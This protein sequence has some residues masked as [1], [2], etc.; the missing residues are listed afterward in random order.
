MV[1]SGKELADAVAKYARQIDMVCKTLCRK[2]GGRP[3]EH[4]GAVVLVLA[5]YLDKDDHSG[6]FASYFYKVGVDQ[7]YSRWLCHDSEQAR[8]SRRASQRRE[9]APRQVG[10]AGVV[11]TDTEASDVRK[12]ADR[13][14]EGLWDL[15]VRGLPSDEGGPFVAYFRG[16]KGPQ[17]GRTRRRR[18]LTMKKVRERLYRDVRFE[19]LWP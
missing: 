6:H 5:E 16:Q 13:L 12:V 10:L 2:H 18:H 4:L 11:L 9:S 15:A 1:A 7:A 17:N 14:G 19:E 3:E 8:Q